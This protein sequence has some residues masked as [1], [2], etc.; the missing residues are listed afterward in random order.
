LPDCRRAFFPVRVRGMVL[1][2]IADRKNPATPIAFR[3]APLFRICEIA[4]GVESAIALHDAGASS[5][6]A[7]VNRRNIAFIGECAYCRGQRGYVPSQMKR[8]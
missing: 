1:R 2:G 5:H 7:A 6:Y 4:G 3:A 8:N